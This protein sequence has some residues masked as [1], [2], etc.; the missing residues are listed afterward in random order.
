VQLVVLLEAVVI[1]AAFVWAARYHFVSKTWTTG[2]RIVTAL[3]LIG[4]ITFIALMTISDSPLLGLGLASLIFG[5]SAALFFWAM[6][7][8]RGTTLDR[9]CVPATPQTILRSG[10]YAYVRHPFYTAYILYWAGCALATWHPA[11]VIVFVVLAAAYVLA[12]RREEA[13][14]MT[15]AL[16]ADYAAYRRTT[17][18]FWVKPQRLRGY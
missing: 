3:S 15:S 4:I 10:P 17:G 9:V 16:R 6:S 12:A 11:L 7:V 5:A 2:T 8:S 13:S 1:F 18:M 14:I